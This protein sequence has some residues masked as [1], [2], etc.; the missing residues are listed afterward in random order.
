M[1][2]RIR[3][4]KELP[5]FSRLASLSVMFTLFASMP[6][7]AQLNDRPAASPNGIQLGDAVTQRWQVGAVVQAPSG[8]VRNLLITIPVPTDWPEQIV[9]VVDEDLS[10]NIGRV[11]YRVVD[12]GVKQ[13]IVTIPA[14]APGGEV[15]AVLTFEIT[16]YQVSPPEDTDNLV[17]PRNPPKDVRRHL[18][19]SPYINS[20]HREIRRKTLEVVEGHETAWSQIEA[21]YDW[22][23]DN[24]ETTNE[25]LKGANETLDDGEGTAEDAVNLFVAMCRAHRVPA[26]IVWVQGHYY[27]EFYLQDE[28][29]DGHWFPCQVAG[30]R[31]FGGMS[32][33]RPILQRGDNIKVPEKKEPYRYV[34]ELVKG[35]AGGGRPS[36][37]FI[38]EL[39]PTE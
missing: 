19:I 21:L 20:R 38:R 11:A 10:P 18:G 6:C 22:V 16:T 37:K 23:R 1:H 15:H 2:Q 13:M 36:V 25:R 29:G 28:N 35:S 7:M 8:P 12:A 31:D 14:V 24:I 34:P 3:F 17:V 9:K 4:S 27:P 32:E 33:V 26:R 39:L 5:V 30:N